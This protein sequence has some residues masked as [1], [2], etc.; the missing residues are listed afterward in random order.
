MWATTPTRSPR[1]EPS[2]AWLE[3]VAEAREAGY[4][5]GSDNSSYFYG[6]ALRFIAD[7]PLR[8]AAL[9]AEETGQFWSG[10]EIGRNRNIYFQ[11]NYSALLA[12]ALWKMALWRCGNRVAL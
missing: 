6:R 12:L 10:D 3:L 1:A 4:R 11:R 7:E 8:Y 2:Q 5:N 9:L